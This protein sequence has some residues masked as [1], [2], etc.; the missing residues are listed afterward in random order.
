MLHRT[1]WDA[2]SASSK[3]EVSIRL[4]TGVENVTSNCMRRAVRQFEKEVSFKLGKGVENVTS[5]CM[6]RTVRQFEKEELVLN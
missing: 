6:E 3:K 1:V 4:E 2:P 5:N